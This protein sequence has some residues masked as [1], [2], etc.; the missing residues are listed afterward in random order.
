MLVN[1]RLLRF[2]AALSG[3]IVLFAPSCAAARQTT[4]TGSLG[5]GYNYWERTYKSENAEAYLNDGDRRDWSVWPEIELRSIGIHDLLS[6]RYRPVLTYDD[7]RDTTY[8]DHYLTLAGQR[9]LTRNWNVSL[10]NNF[11]LSTDPTRD[12]TPFSRLGHEGTPQGPATQNAE[13]NRDT[14]LTQN[15][16]RRRYWTNDLTARTNYTYAA[17]SEVGVGYA[18]NVLRN[19]SGDNGIAAEY[20]EY[21]RHDFSGLFSYRFN[22][23]WKSN[24]ELHYIEG[25][26]NDNGVAP[27]AAAGEAPA[28]LSSDLQ[29]YRADFGVDYNRRVTDTFPLLYKF[30]E[31]RYD[32]YRRNDIWVHELTVGWDHALDERTHL[33][34]GGGPAYVDAEDMNGEWVY[35][36]YLTFTRAYQHANLSARLEKTYATENFTGAGDI[37]LSDIIEARTDLTY[38]F[39]EK[40]SSGIFGLYRY[41]AILNPHGEYYQAATGNEVPSTGRNVGDVTYIENG[42]SAGANLDYRFLR[43]FVAS[44]RYVYYKQD[45]DL[46]RDSY[47]DNRIMLQL[48]VT[49]ELWR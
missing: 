12:E 23:A 9:S 43:W 17:D 49:K 22:P 25:L 38:R 29:E 20:E 4:V 13:Q 5:M 15:L 24:L 47:T 3:A 46:L 41:R 42:Y 28:R 27:T 16:G 10:S 6:L 8:V 48:A 34:I 36:L 33:I 35:S 19:E 1:S 45:A 14:Q 37:G 32:D 30:R 18:Y 2:A 26:Y 40:L 7:L 44:V 31:T 21:D 11:V 39:T